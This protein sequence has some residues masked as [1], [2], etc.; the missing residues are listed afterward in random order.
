MSE[1]PVDDEVSARRKAREEAGIEAVTARA[2]AEAD[3][4]N[5]ANTQALA[6]AARDFVMCSF[7]FRQ[8]PKGTTSYKRQ[9][10]EMLL[11]I[12]CSAEHGMPYGQDRLIP[13]WLATAFFAA[14]KPK[15]NVIR[16]RCAKDILRAFGLNTDGGFTLARLHERLERVYYARYFGS[17]IYTDPKGRRWKKDYSYHLMHKVA[18]WTSDH[19]ARRSPNQYTLWQDEIHLGHEFA[20]DLRAGGRVPIDLETVKALKECSPALDLYVWQAWRSY[21]MQ[22]AGDETVAVPIFGPDGLVAQLGS[23]SSSTKKLKAMLRGWQREVRR[24]WPTCPNYLDDHCERF[25]V[26]PGAAHDIDKRIPELPGVS[27]TPPPKRETKPDDFLAKDGASL[28][29]V[30]DDDEN[31]GANDAG[32]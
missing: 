15:D 29:L 19:D 31:A 27:P 9:N 18:M 2:F 11:E 23:S 10:G 4:A 24:V 30:R 13:I 17:T 16:L 28:I 5:E 22:R 1:A 20:E 26:H 3:A 7:P 8:P 12:Q 21:R 32:A 25:I 14:G 6:Y